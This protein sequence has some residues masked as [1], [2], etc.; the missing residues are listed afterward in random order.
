MKNQI[1]MFF[2][3]QIMKMLIVIIFVQANFKKLQFLL[4][5]IFEKMV[6]FMFLFKKLFKKKIQISKYF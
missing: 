1:F 4:F 2:V 3:V 5:K 6:I